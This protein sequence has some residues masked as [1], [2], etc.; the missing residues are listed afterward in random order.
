M[1]RENYINIEIGKSKNIKRE[2]YKATLFYDALEIKIKK[3]NEILYKT[4]ILPERFSFKKNEV[5]LQKKIDTILK[6]IKID[7]FKFKITEIS[8]FEKIYYN[9]ILFLKKF[10]SRFLQPTQWI[11][12]YKNILASEW[13]YLN[14]SNKKMQ[15]DP[16]IIFESGKY[17][18]FFEEL[19]FEENKGYI[20]VGELDLKEKKLIN[21][22]I[23]LEKD[24]HLSYPFVFKENNTW[25]MIPESSENKKID[26]YEAEKFPY[27]WRLKKTLI[28]NIEAVD[29]TLI[30]NDSIWYLFTSEK[31]PGISTNDELSIYYSEDF[32]NNEFKKLFLNPVISDISCARMGG[33]F[34]LKDKKIYRVSQNCLKRYGYQVNINEIIEIDKNNYKEQKIE[35]LKHPKNKKII[36]MH[37][38]NFS[39]EIEVADFLVLRN[40]I[41][42]LV[43]NFNT[44]V[45]RFL[46]TI[47]N[48]IRKI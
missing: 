27:E 31:Q 46:N 41:N 30:K 44:K 17:F 21:E 43:T 47:K 13:N 20:S 22:K 29:A 14:I 8:F 33:N 5:I 9:M 28:D 10:I 37:T 45:K 36:G 6:R 35:V 38:Y 39:N 3:E 4:N 7:N 19:Y 18:I 11:I 1:G 42:G 48:K 12:G 26:L 25:Y 15:A 16:F 40:D 2:I 34:F 23:I 32:L 24:Y